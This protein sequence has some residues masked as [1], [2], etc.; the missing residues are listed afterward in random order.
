MSTVHVGGWFEVKGKGYVVI[1]MA[2]HDVIPW[3]LGHY[4]PK[5]GDEVC[6]IFD[7]QGRIEKVTPLQVA[8]TLTSRPAARNV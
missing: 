4:V 3:S 1:G 2:K 8:K 5:V 6:V 7:D